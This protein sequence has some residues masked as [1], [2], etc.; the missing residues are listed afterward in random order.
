MSVHAAL[1][2]FRFAIV[3]GLALSLTACAWKHGAAIVLEKEHIDV[4]ESTL[5]PSSPSPVAQV[6]GEITKSPE[7]EEPLVQEMALDEI[8][9][10][11]YVMK[12]ELRGTSK[13]PRAGSEVKWLVNLAMTQG[14][15]PLNVHTDRAHYERLKLNDRIKVKYSEGKYTST[16]WSAEIEDYYSLV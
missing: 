16:A 2:L 12:K 1:F 6:T 10:D 7:G 8:A 4:A 14:G 9:V 15:R 5:S 3:A 11:G 13:D